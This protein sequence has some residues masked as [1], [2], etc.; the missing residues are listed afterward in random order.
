M[1]FDR[2]RERVTLDASIH[3]RN[4]E[5]S[6]C[7]RWQHGGCGDD[8]DTRPAR[9]D[10]AELLSEIAIRAKGY[11]GYDQAFLDACRAELTFTPAEIAPRRIAVVESSQQVL[12]FYSLDGEAPEGELGNLWVVPESI[13]TGLGRRIWEAAMRSPPLGSSGCTRLKIDAEPRAEGFYLA[14]GAVRVGEV[15]SGSVPGRV[16]PLLTVRPE[17]SRSRRAGDHEPALTRS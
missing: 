6:E 9:E 4:S 15:P 1:P 17:Q 11:W 10:E 2:L 3:R 13:G 12:G 5:P 7:E 14:M 8:S 16:I